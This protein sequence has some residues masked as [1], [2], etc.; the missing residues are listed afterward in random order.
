MHVEE[1]K[2]VYVEEKECVFGRDRACA[3]LRVCVCMRF[4]EKKVCICI[5]KRV[6]TWQRE[7]VRVIARSCFALAKR[8]YGTLH[9]F[10]G[11]CVSIFL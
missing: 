8:V 10:R 6:C 11:V 7:C 2:S 1:S 9:I 4:C 5:R 3:Q